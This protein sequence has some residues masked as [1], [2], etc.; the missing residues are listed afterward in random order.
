[1]GLLQCDDLLDSDGEDEYVPNESD[2]SFDDMI[3]PSQPDVSIAESSEEDDLVSG[4]C[5]VDNPLAV[6]EI[7]VT[8]LNRHWPENLGFAIQDPSDT[9]LPKQ[10]KKI[11]PIKENSAKKR[12][13]DESEWKKLQN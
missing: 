1:M 8:D 11:F 13:R 5:E 9:V 2:S 6:D 10:K 7:P 3:L 4:N 12:F